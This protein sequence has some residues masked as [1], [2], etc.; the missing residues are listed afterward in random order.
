MKINAGLWEQPVP[1]LREKEAD[2]KA[3]SRKFFLQSAAVADCLLKDEEVYLSSPEADPDNVRYQQ[4]GVPGFKPSTLRKHLAGEIRDGGSGTAY[5]VPH[6]F[7]VLKVLKGE[8]T[9]LISSFTR[10][11]SRVKEKRTGRFVP[12]AEFD[13]RARALNRVLEALDRRGRQMSAKAA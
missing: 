2:M 4:R 5:V 12:V 6:P 9:K 7:A 10:V 11:G 1:R 13:L 3:P 8:R